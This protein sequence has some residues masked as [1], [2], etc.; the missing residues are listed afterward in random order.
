ML[1]D[2]K[3]DD[4]IKNHAIFYRQALLV[5]LTSFA[6]VVSIIILAYQTLL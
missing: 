3:K 6:S 5:R 2:N 4:E 1:S